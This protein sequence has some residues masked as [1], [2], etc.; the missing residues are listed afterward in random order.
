M[1]KRVL[2]LFLTISLLG[3][4]T[5]STPAIAQP[6]LNVA[7]ITQTNKDVNQNLNLNSDKKTNDTNENN[8]ITN[9]S[10]EIKQE[11]ETMPLYR[12]GGLT[13]FIKRAVKIFWRISDSI[14]TFEKIWNG[15]KKLVTS[16]YDKDTNV[17]TNPT[18]NLVG[19]GLQT[20]GGNVTEVQKLLNQNG[21]ALA[22][23]GI[24]G[25][26]TKEAVKTFQRSKGLSPDGIVGYHTWNALHGN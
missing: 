15:T 25:P 13:R 12:S 5:F 8:T 22:E 26:K 11:S 10:E 17:R 19:D 6:N 14:E 18:Y 1:N 20:I 16:F 2:S 4:V 23:D 9:N 21:H 24:W 3:T 7:E